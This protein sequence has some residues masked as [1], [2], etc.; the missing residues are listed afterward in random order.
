MAYK[1][2]SLNFGKLKTYMFISVD[3]S[4]LNDP[5][6]TSNLRIMHMIWIIFFGLIF[7]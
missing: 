6:L 5:C 4:E 2:L 7:G 1:L 3:V